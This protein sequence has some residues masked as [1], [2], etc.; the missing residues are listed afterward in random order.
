MP[1]ASPIA[2]SVSGTAVPELVTQNRGV[3]GRGRVAGTEL[4]LVTGAG[5]QVVHACRGQVVTGVTVGV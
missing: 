4:A 2:S 5:G 1:P 3:E